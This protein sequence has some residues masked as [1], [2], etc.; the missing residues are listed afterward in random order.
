MVTDIKVSLTVALPGRTMVSKEESLKNPMLLTKEVVKIYDVKT[1]RINNVNIF[2]RVTKP[3]SQ[4]LNICSEAYKKM[5]SSSTPLKYEGTSHQW[6]KLN[7]NDR[8]LW[9]LENIAQ[10]LGGVIMS[11]EVFPD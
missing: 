9:H 7:R 4:S 1:N 3:A 6:N 8:L 11:Y 5:I 10:E 2:T